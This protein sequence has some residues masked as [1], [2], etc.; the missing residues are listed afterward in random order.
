MDWRSDSIHLTDSQSSPGVPAQNA[1]EDIPAEAGSAQDSSGGQEDL[2]KT[3]MESPIDPPYLRLGLELLIISL[4]SQVS[5]LIV[6]TVALNMVR[7]RRAP[8]TWYRRDY[9]GIPIQSHDVPK[10]PSPLSYQAESG[11]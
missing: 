5:L 1:G 8:F 6:R 7:I 3:K 4:F 9:T 11:P 2:K 10:N